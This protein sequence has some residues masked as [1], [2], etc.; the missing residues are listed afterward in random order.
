MVSLNEVCRDDLTKAEINRQ[1]A[2]HVRLPLFMTK[3]TTSEAYVC[4]GTA[5]ERCT[6]RFRKVQW[7]YGWSLPRVDD[8]PSTPHSLRPKEH[9][10]QC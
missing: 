2:R 6:A 10:Q 4:L 5:L 8:K 1:K 9:M 7:T 3:I